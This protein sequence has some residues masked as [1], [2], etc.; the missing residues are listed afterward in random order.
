MS[1]LSELVSN[2]RDHSP[3]VSVATDTYPSAEIVY[4]Q[5]QELE[6]NGDFEEAKRAY[7][8]AKDLDALRFRASEEFNLIIHRLAETYGASVVPMQSV[9]ES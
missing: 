1:V 6:Q 5:A 4:Q 9:F 3:F 7:T 2:V 8:V